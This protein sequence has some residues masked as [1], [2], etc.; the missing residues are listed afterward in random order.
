M[1]LEAVDQAIGSLGYDE[2]LR[3]L[4]AHN[5]RLAWNLAGCSVA[6]AGHDL[7]IKPLAALAL[8][9]LEE[10]IALAKRERANGSK[11]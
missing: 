9:V 4:Q 10:V 7:D 5:E 11:D 8:P 3:A 2:E 6:A 1:I